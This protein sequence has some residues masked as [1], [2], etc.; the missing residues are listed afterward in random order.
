MVIIEVDGKKFEALEEENLLQ[1]LLKNKFPIPH[2][3]Y[4]LDYEPAEACRLCLVEVNGRIKTSCGVKIKDGMKIITTS[5][6]IK[7]LQIINSRLIAQ[8]KLRKQNREKFNFDKIIEF[9]MSKCVDC[10]LCIRGCPILAIAFEGYGVDQK[11]APTKNPCVFC[12]QCLTRCPAN[13]INTDEEEYQ[14]IKKFIKSKKIKI[15]QVAPSI[16]TSLGELFNYSHEKMTGEK[17]VAALKAL[18][19]D[20][21]FDTSLGADF[22]TFEEAKELVF[23][24]KNDGFLPMLTSC[25]AGW[26]KYVKDHIPRFLPYLTA[27]LPPEIILGNLIK[28]YFIKKM[29]FNQQDVCLVSIMPCT[30]KKWEIKRKELLVDGIFPVDEVLTTVELGRWLKEEAVDFVNL[31]EKE[32][33]QPL[34]GASGAG[35]IYGTTGGVMTSALRTAYYLLTQKDPTNLYFEE[36]ITDLAGVKIFEIKIEERTLK[37]AVVNGLGNFNQ[38][39]NRLEEFHYVEVMACPGG[40]LSGGGQPKPVNNQIRQ[41]RKAVLFGIDQKKAVRTSHNNPFLKQVYQEF[42]TDEK[43]I[44]KYCQVMVEPH[45]AKS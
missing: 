20:Y 9:D 18:G 45:G 29:G 39:A 37:I 34:G 28:H 27:T 41:K 11:V 1:F 6:K 36:K 23:R 35:V 12:G 25:C 15:A 7:K 31:T 14:R 19:F 38:I 33:D 8:S 17:V 21:V 44:S 30:A 40:C 10:G 2:L 43:Q 22:T 13:A 26:V 32:F 3:C 42:L 4:H 24:I 16:R 5:E